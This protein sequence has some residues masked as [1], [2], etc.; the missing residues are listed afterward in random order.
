[1]CA[2]FGATVEAVTEGDEPDDEPVAPA[3]AMPAVESRAAV[4][5]VVMT[6]RSFMN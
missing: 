1:M 2:A 4:V 3:M 5:A 6:V